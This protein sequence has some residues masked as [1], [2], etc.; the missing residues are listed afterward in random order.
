[1]GINFMVDED[2]NGYWVWIMKMNGYY[3]EQGKAGA[4]LSYFNSY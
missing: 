1:M 2:I 4:F 3:F